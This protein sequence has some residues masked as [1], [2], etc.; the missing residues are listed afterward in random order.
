MTALP[1]VSTEV[2]AAALDLLPARL[3]KRLDGAVAKAAGWPVQVVADGLVVRVAEDTEVTLVLSPAGIVADADDA[4]CSCLLA[5]ACLHRA[6]V[7]SSAPLAEPHAEAEH[8][9]VEHEEA[10][11]REA[12]GDESTG[13]GP[14]PEAASTTDRTGSPTP[15]HT[16][17]LTSEHT[18][19]P[20]PEQEPQPYPGADGTP[21]VP[22]AAH[23]LWEAGTEVLSTGVTGAGAHHRAQL[24]HAAHSARL[25]GLH[26]ESATAVRIARHLGAAREND[27][28]FRLA[29]LTDELTGLLDAVRRPGRA[30]AARRDYRPG[31]PLRLHGLFTEPVVTAS[32]Y[33][34]ATTHA[35]APDGTLRTLSDIAPGGPGRAV[36]AAGSSVPGGCALPLRELGAG[37]GVILTSPTVSADGRIGGGKQV[38]SVRASGAEWHEAPLDALWQQPPSAQL[39]AVLRAPAA[40]PAGGGLLFLDGTL[41]TD[42]ALAV[43]RGPVLRLLAPDERPELPYAENL[44]LLTSYPGLPLRLIGRIRQDR[45]GGISVLAASW[46]ATDGSEFRADLGLRRLNR[47]QLPSVVPPSGSMTG[48]P[49]VLPVELDLLRRAVD[50]TVAGGRPVA[51]ADDELPGRLR[52]AGLTTGADC[53]HALTEAAAARH[54]DVLGRLLPTDKDAF[55]TAWLATALYARAAVAALLVAAWTA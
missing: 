26:E 3:R 2:A 42:G 40:S 45:P 52:A 12:D 53:A 9:E 15:D 32:G 30:T 55:A 22:A 10:E 20:T 16:R 43:T 14:E 39:A 35:L 6:A 25:A 33:S 28:A 7:L 11:H 37:G 48:T 31:G 44:R 27:P 54:H 8:E 41:T 47:A 17:S 5:P 49:L 4:V 19:P 23:A 13:P 46:T 24:L 21:G 36:Q 34:G 38:R 50:R 51:A 18:R 1:P 29:E